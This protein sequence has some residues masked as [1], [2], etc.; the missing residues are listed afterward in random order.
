MKILSCHIENFGKLRDYSINFSDGAN[1][2]CEE[3]GWG[4]STFVAFVRAMFYGLDG[5]RKR[6][7]EE[8]ERK[9]YKPWQGGIFGGQLVFEM[10]GKTYV[11]SRI[12]KDKEANDE[13]EIRDRATNLPVK[14]YTKKIGEEI[15]QVS[16]ESFGRTVCI[17]QNQCET[18]PTDDIHAKIGQ[19]VDN[20][21]DLNCFEAAAAKLTEMLHKLNPNRA[22]GSIERRGEEIVRY[23]RLVK[24]GEQLSESMKW[25]QEKLHEEEAAYQSLKEQIQETAKTQKTASE[26]QFILAKKS[27][28]ARLKQ[29]V[30]KRAQEKEAC[31]QKFPGSIPELEQVKKQQSVCSDAKRVRERAVWYQMSQKEKDEF[32]SIERSFAAGLPMDAEFGDMLQKAKT[33]QELHQAYL[34]GQL[35]LMEQERLDELESHFANDAEH[36]TSVMRKWN[37][38]NAKKDALPPKREAFSA[39]QAA[40]QS[41]QQRQKKK[42]TFL[43]IAAFL[44]IAAGTAV[45]IAVSAA[46]G[47]VLAAVLIAAGIGL[48]LFGLL[49]R[50]KTD[51][52][53]AGMSDELEKLRR[54]IAQD[55]QYAAKTERETADY[56]AAH[57]KSFDGQAVSAS[58][59]E[60]LAESVEYASLKKKRQNAQD[61]ENAEALE[62]LQRTLTDF[63]EHYGE[64]SDSAG[65]SERLYWL[66]E[67]AEKYQA[68]KEKQRHFEQAANEYRE[69][70]GENI[71]FL[72]EYNYDISPDTASQLSDI[73]DAVSAY[74]NACKALEDAKKE[75][76]Q[77]ETDNAAFSWNNEAFL[78]NENAQQTEE[79]L[80]TLDQ[81]NAKMQQLTEE[82]EKVHH[83]ITY[84]NKALEDLQEQY[85]E[86]EENAAKLEELKV[87]QAKEK[88]TYK[89]VNIAKTKLELA[90]EALTAKYA[91]PIFQGFSRYYQM[92][93]GEE[94]DCF[95]MD[96][97][98]SVTVDEFGKQ[99]ETNTLSAGY[100]DLIGI[101]LRIAFTDAM[102]PQEKPPLIMDDPFADLDDKKVA[103]GMDFL[104]KLAEKHQI[105]YF[106]C[107]TSRG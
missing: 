39:L 28:W 34:S 85:D 106:T 66:K 68:Y 17:T 1:I 92:I 8:N 81:L 101:C 62:N 60:I 56:L 59:Q 30:D 38:R 4:K 95:H 20:S 37:D 74:Q 72:K 58:L 22:T 79:M 32:A 29:A 63:L 107:S 98:A 100:R 67:K 12:F 89:Y 45:G 57:G 104:K 48:A 75:Q 42:A 77:F 55:E 44:C 26:Q 90:K 15:F 88:K 87:L 49:T 41:R 35:S 31:E 25:H 105:I 71:S 54:T 80:P 43:W 91:D 65:L 93:S 61:S 14:D 69:L 18:F 50:K 16:R 19:L 2:I 102:Y 73:W 33:F 11:I 47:T 64:V 3:N 21:N 13:F 7:I 53:Q 36:V 23:E 103:A 6:S 70:Q 46:A 52:Q 40:V 86:W 94:T 27:E 83:Q 97:N 76:K 10:Q 84:Y 5:D 99:R 82:R 24:N 51:T 96:A 78:Q 9:R